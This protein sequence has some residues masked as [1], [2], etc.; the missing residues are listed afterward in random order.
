MLSAGNSEYLRPLGSSETGMNTCTSHSRGRGIHAESLIGLTLTECFDIEAMVQQT[1]ARCAYLS[2]AVL[3]WPTVN[4]TGSVIGGAVPA[5]VCK[6]LQAQ[7]PSV[8]GYV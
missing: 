6:G 1:S 5:S 3:S 8:A 4:R 2:V 7:L